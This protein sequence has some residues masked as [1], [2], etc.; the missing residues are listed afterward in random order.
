MDKNTILLDVN[1]YNELRDFK[2]KIE[3]GDFLV[4]VKIFR[5]GSH[6]Q[7]YKTQI[8]TKETTIK[9][10]TDDNEVLRKEIDNLIDQL[11]PKQ[12]EISLEDIKKMSY[13]EFRKWKKSK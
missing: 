11:N 9:M 10:L 2:N 13:W 6:I 12:K 8:Y 3:N 1:N 4:S 5:N 7:T